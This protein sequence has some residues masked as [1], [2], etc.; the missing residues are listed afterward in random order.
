[1]FTL[2]P[3]K[4]R[5]PLLYCSSRGATKQGSIAHVSSRVAPIEAP[6]V[7]QVGMRVVLPLNCRT[8]ERS[9]RV[10]RRNK[11]QFFATS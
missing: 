1:M 6:V 9:D 11:V 3:G 4:A 10:S 2:S 5:W 7:M 8:E